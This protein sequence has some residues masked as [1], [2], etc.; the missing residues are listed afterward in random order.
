MFPLSNAEW[1]RRKSEIH[2]PSFLIS[3]FRLPRSVFEGAPTLYKPRL[4]RNCA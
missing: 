1:G 2:A 3:D 4:R